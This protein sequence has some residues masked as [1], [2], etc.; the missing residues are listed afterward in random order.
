[1]KKLGFGCMRLPVLDPQDQSTFDYDKI[2]ALFDAFIEEGFSYFDTAYVYH[3]YQAERAV[4]DCLVKRHKRDDFV[5]AT[6]LPMR[7]I[8]S[9]AD[10]ERVFSEQ[11]D[12]CGAEYFDYY[13]LHN[14][15][16]NT[17]RT[18]QEL[19]S[20]AFGVRK[21]AEGKIRNFGFSFH[22]TPELLDEILTAHPEAD[23]V[24]LQI[25]YIDWE[26]PSIQSRRCYEVAQRHGKP[27]IVMEPLKGGSLA[28]VP[29]EAEKLMKQARPSLSVPSWGIRFAAGLDGVICVLSGMNSFAQLKDNMSYMSDFTPLGGEES[30]VLDAVTDIINGD[31]AVACTACRYCTHGCPE[32]IAIP[33]YFALY[34]SVKRASSANFSSQSVYYMNLSASHGKASDCIGCGQCESACP[35]HLN[36][37]DSLRDVAAAFEDVSPFPTKK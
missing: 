29:A 27:V 30:K 17:Y 18:A 1:M 28:S 8:R 16:V 7:D 26:N 23:F 15:G 6:K 34:N 14:L 9:E 24:Q 36:I 5:L 33:D 32:N 11:L 21:K 31:T 22:D 13:L 4:R 35:Q 10:Q 37:I 20:F 2:C 3:N 19:G 25:N 12:H